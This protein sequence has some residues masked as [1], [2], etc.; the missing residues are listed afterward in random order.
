MKYAEMLPTQEPFIAIGLRNAD[1]RN[2]SI[3]RLGSQDQTVVSLDAA[4]ASL[5]SEAMPPDLRCGG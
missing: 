2:V 4:L 3:R 1:A 5:K